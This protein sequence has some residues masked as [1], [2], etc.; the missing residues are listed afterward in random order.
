MRN[1]LQLHSKSMPGERH[2]VGFSLHLA[3]FSDDSLS[4]AGCVHKHQTSLSS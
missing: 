3:K 4:L 1:R 2:P